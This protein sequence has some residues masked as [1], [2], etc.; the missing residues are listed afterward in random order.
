LSRYASLAD[1]KAYG[2][3]E[4]AAEDDLLQMALERAED[5]I[6]AAT[7]SRFYLA[8]WENVQ[9]FA[10]RATRYGWLELI[11]REGA[12]VRAVLSVQVRSPGGGWTEIP[13][14]DPILPSPDIAPP[15]KNAWSVRIP[16][17][18]VRAFPSWAWGWTWPP[19]GDFVFDPGEWAWRWTYQAGYDIIPTSL[20]LL[21]LRLAW[22][23]YKQREAPMERVSMLDVRVV[24]LPLKLP[25]D[26]DSE[27][28]AWRRV[29]V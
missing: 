27:L 17:D 23:I 3:V 5:L 16:F 21:T 15:K 4:S 9:P 18:G 6:H 8:T 28:K 25:P 2:R 1:L 24:T 29:G 20:R 26:L 12:P 10:V 7:G 11:A 22:W 14:V 13:V 19:V